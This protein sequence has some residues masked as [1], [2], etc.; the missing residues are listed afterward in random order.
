MYACAPSLTPQVELD[1]DQPMTVYVESVSGPQH[2]FTAT[3]FDAQH[4]PG[5]AMFLFEGEFGTILYTGDFRYLQ[6]VSASLYISVQLL[7]SPSPRHNHAAWCSLAV[8]HTH[9]HTKPPCC[10]DYLALVCDYMVLH[11][12]QSFTEAE[13]RFGPWDLGPS[14]AVKTGL[15]HPICWL[16]CGLTFPFEKNCVLFATSRKQKIR[17]L[18]YHLNCNALSFC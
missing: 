14:I 4:C 6:T 9:T 11:T 8:H 15:K 16:F 5:S 17:Q 13:P 3:A 18:H 7:C 2:H 10:I 12:Q 1:Y